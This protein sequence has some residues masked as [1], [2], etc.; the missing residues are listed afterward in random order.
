MGNE[1]LA[2]SISDEQLVMVM[3]NVIRG[4]KPN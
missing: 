4:T 1:Q 2:M 3:V